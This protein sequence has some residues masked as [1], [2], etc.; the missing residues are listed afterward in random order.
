MNNGLTTVE[1]T[2]LRNHF[3]TGIFLKKKEI[4]TE[5]KKILLVTAID[6]Q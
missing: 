3:P 2:I 1:K 4:A 6:E 5:E